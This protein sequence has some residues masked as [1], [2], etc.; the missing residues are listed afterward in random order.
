MKTYKIIELP[1]FEGK[2][3]QEVKDYLEKEYPNRLPKIEDFDLETLSKDDNWYFF[4]GS[5]VRYSYGHWSVPCA[6][7]DGSAWY[8]DG[9]WLGLRWGSSARVVLLETEKETDK[10][11]DFCKV[12][13]DL[14][15]F[16]TLDTRVSKL[17]S[18]V[19]K[20]LEIINVK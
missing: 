3:L 13:T 10:E 12:S 6:S 5:L 17:E 9:D 11:K 16:E 20:L 15:N 4:F 1:Q 8:R 19:K 18:K 14:P 7:W 2:T